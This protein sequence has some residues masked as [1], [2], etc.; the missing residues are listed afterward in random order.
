MPQPDE[1]KRRFEAKQSIKFR[2]GSIQ[3]G[4]RF[5]F[6]DFFLFR[7]GTT[8]GA[9]IPAGDRLPAIHNVHPGRSYSLDGDNA[10][11][12]EPGNFLVL[13]VDAS[14]TDL[15]DDVKQEDFADRILSFSRWENGAREALLRDPWGWAER[16]I[17]MTGNAAKEVRPYPY[18]A[19]VLLLND[20]RAAGLVGDVATEYRGPDAGSHDFELASCSVECKA[21]LHA[22]PDKPG[23]IT[24]SSQHQ[25]ARTG[26][27]PL[28]LA[29]FAMEDTGDLTVEEAA[30]AF[31]EPRAVLL[32]KL[33]KTGIEEGDFAWFRPYHLVCEPLVY[34]I[35]GSFPRIT[36]K[37]FPDGKFPAGIVSLEYH[38]SLQNLPRCTLGDFVAALAA[39]SKPTFTT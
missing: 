25:L 37:T 22:A 20:L 19:E 10:V 11:P 35:D 17:E 7:R 30:R 31:G 28:Y 21:H 5:Q 12:G 14:E 3:T 6:D 1:A 26:D 13:S 27:K 18:L 32:E 23:E 15:S 16:I 2:L 4:E 9:A 33:R 39:G 29:Y 8:V 34:E 24:V 36:P 38:V